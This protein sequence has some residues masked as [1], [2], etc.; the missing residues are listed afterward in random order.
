M[1]IEILPSAIE[2]LADGFN[3]YEKQD[4]GLGSYFLESLYSDI[5]SLRLYAEIGRAHV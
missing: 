5:D 4:E 2:D 1:K 3:F